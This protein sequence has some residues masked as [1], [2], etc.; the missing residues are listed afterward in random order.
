M[1][2]HACNIHIG[3]LW[4]YFFV[5]VVIILS[6]FL[7]GFFSMQDFVSSAEIYAHTDGDN[8]R[9]IRSGFHQ[10]AYSWLHT[11]VEY[12]NVVLVRAIWHEYSNADRLPND[13][14]VIKFYQFQ[15][16][17]QNNTRD[18]NDFAKKCIIT[19]KWIWNAPMV[20]KNMLSNCVHVIFLKYSSKYL[21][22]VYVCGSVS[23]V[24]QRFLLYLIF[25]TKNRHNM[26][27]MLFNQKNR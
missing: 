23:S 6:L 2:I 14:S 17:N 5:V 27:A 7:R 8:V 12:I 15:L 18:S 3:I 19:S 26:H 20:V 1:T 10:L 22:N 13:I 24:L 9:P 21:W 11:L 16:K 4:W 25:I